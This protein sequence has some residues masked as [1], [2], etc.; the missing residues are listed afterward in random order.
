MDILHPLTDAFAT[1]SRLKFIPQ[2]PHETYYS[3]RYLF[4][5]VL[6]KRTMANVFLHRCCATQINLRREWGHGAV[7]R[8]F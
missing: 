5:Q 8:P 6:P 4:L 1:Q 3:P 2:T 7:M